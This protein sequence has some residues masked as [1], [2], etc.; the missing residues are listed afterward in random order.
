MR[1]DV[2]VSNSTNNRDVS[3]RSKPRSSTLYINTLAKFTNIKYCNNRSVESGRVEIC[4]TTFFSN[5][6]QLLF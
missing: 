1:N 5:E 2:G 3:Y 6:L 4:L